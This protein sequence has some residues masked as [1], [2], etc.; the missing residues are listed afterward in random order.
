MSAGG[1][2]A[3]H[4]SPVSTRLFLVVAA[5]AVFVSVLTATMINVLIPLIRAQFD[6]SAAGVGWVATGYFLA[7]AIGVPLYGRISDFFGVREIGR[8]HV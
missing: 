5:S 7:Y 6:A 2:A 1:E 4:E 8:A 3:R